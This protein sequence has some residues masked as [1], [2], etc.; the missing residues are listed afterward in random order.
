MDTFERME[1]RYPL[2]RAVKERWTG[3]C[4]AVSAAAKPF[5][6]DDTFPVS[7]FVLHDVLGA[8]AALD[9]A[10]EDASKSTK[11]TPINGMFAMTRDGPVC[12]V[13]WME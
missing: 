2:P 9:K 13:W 8:Q 12:L 7:I 1:R 4:S 6:G 11:D 5:T 3:L 10:I